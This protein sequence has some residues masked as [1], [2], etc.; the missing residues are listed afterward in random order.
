MTTSRITTVLLASAIAACGGKTA[1]QVSPPAV[2][3]ARPSDPSADAAPRE[4]PPVDAP[5]DA[6]PAPDP[7][8]IQ[9]ALVVAER[10]AYDAAKPAFDRYCAS[11]HQQGGKKATRKKLGHFDITA[12]PFTGHHTDEIGPT[13]RE[14]LAIGGG[15]PTMPMD[16]PGSV[17]AEDLALFAAFA[18]AWDRAH[19]GA[20]AAD[21][22][23]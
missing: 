15:K 18:D 1:T 16:K 17:S 12:Y 14:V 5:P 2:I 19:A 21:H 11:C 9:A 8:A 20:A 6:T 4:V 3:D 13:L 22:A 7:V 23:D 10:A